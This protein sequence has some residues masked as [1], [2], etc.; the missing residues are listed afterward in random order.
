MSQDADSGSTD[1]MTDTSG[2]VPDGDTSDT[3]TDDSTSDPDT[4][5]TNDTSGTSDTSDTSDTT[6]TSGGV[7]DGDTSDTNTDDSTSTTSD[8]SDTSGTSDT[9]DTSDTSTT[10]DTSDTSGTSDTTDTSDTSDTPGT[11][12][13]TDTSNTS[14]TSDTTD[15]SDTSGTSDTTDTS[16]GV[17]DGDTSD[18]NT[19]DSTSTTSDTTDTS[20]MSDTSDAGTSATVDYKK[21]VA[22]PSGINPGVSAASQATMMSALGNPGTPQDSCGTPSAGLQRLMKTASVGPFR[23]TGLAPAVYA[24]TRVF[25]AV[26][27]AKPDLYSL[28]GTAG[29]L[30]VRHVRGSTTNFSNHSW[31]TAID[32]T[33]GG[34]LTPRG[35]TTVQQGLVDLAPFMQAEQFFW[36]AAFPTPDGMHFEASNELIAEW[37]SN[38]TIP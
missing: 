28:L 8:T 34:Q 9:T 16:G 6:D 36:G 21:M 23:V 18:T 1:V 27:S 22:I 13:T 7:P 26:K 14:T 37:K 31:G 4:D 17:P 2:G 35:S 12:D 3:N 24:L 11:S 19:D 30:C 29:M 38:H 5:G 33:I 15:T 32:M 10:S 25:A 20:D